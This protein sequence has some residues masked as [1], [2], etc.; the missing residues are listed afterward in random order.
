MI[1]LT[2]DELPKVPLS[3]GFIG[4]F[5]PNRA[6]EGL[7]RVEE[8][9]KVSYPQKCFKRSSVMCWGSE[10]LLST[11]KFRK[12]IKSMKEPSEVLISIDQFLNDLCL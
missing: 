12:V 4:F 5:Y 10:G 7:L 2:I 8:C 3:T 11:E 6:S 9:Q 1:P